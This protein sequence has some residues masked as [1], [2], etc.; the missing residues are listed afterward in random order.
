MK[1]YSF[2]CLL[3]IL[4][5]VF[6]GMLPSAV[7]LEDF[8]TE[9]PASNP[10]YNPNFFFD[11]FSEDCQ[12]PCWY[13]L[14]VGETSEADTLAFLESLFPPEEVNEDLYFLEGTPYNGGLISKSYPDGYSRPEDIPRIA[15][16]TFFK[17]KLLQ[18]IW[19]KMSGNGVQDIL[20]KRVTN[21]MGIPDKVYVLQAN[22]SGYNSLLLSYN[23][24][25]YFK[26]TILFGALEDAILTHEFCLNGNQWHGGLPILVISIIN[27]SAEGIRSLTVE[28]INP[29]DHYVPLDEVSDLNVQE[30]AE[31]LQNDEPICL[32]LTGTV[33]TAVPS[34]IE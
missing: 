3:P 24:G 32:E 23:L 27:P 8:P 2:T 33:P 10:E 31:A 11:G 5:M 15:I 28:R 26:Y 25:I 13:G 19:I 18:G 21:T 17:D 16:T 14:V 9:Q 6:A 7:L 22:Y 30:F 20:P 29:L 4:I 34:D 1:K 12:L